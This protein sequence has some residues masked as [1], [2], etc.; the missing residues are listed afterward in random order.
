M[1]RSKLRFHPGRAQSLFSLFASLR[2]R[3]EERDGARFREGEL[4]KRE[5]ERDGARCRE[6]ELETTDCEDGRRV[7]FVLED[8]ETGETEVTEERED[9]RGDRRAE[10]VGEAGSGEIGRTRVLDGE[11]G[12]TRVWRAWR[13]DTV[14]GE[15]AGGVARGEA[16]GEAST[17]GCEEVDAGAGD[18]NT[19]SEGTHLRDL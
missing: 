10:T 1:S 13:G 6:G 15:V 4:R 16:C 9:R 12:R 17:E 14:R 5:E 11:I 18:E 8:E 19:I 7:V 2:K 3:E